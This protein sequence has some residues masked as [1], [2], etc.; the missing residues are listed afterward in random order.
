[1]FHTIIGYNP[2]KDTSYKK[3]SNTVKKIP[4]NF[5]FSP[6]TRPNY[7]FGDGFRRDVNHFY[8]WEWCLPHSIT[9]H[10][11]SSSFIFQ[12]LNI[13]LRP[14]QIFFFDKQSKITI[15][16]SFLSYIKKFFIINFT[17]HL[18]SNWAKIESNFIT[19]NQK[20]IQEQYHYY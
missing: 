9:P 8:Y 11:S 5:C 10:L 13:T 14:S 4:T 18:I 12:S 6:L 20:T 2:Y 15:F 1:M 7:F 16:I 17:T 19:Y 3:S